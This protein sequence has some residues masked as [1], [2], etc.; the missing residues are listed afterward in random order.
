[1][2]VSNLKNKIRGF[3]VHNGEGPYSH[4][5]LVSPAFL[6]ALT[7]AT[8]LSATQKHCCGVY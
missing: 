3:K 8:A 2:R 1:M 7:P 4:P 5:D 6:R